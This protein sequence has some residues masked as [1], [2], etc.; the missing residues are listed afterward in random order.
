MLDPALVTTSCAELQAELSSC[1]AECSSLGQQLAAAVAGQAAAQRELGAVASARHE[2]AV[3]R[4]AIQ[5]ELA[6]V[7]TQDC[8]AVDP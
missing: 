4:N 6:Q 8:T 5:R 1:R 3:S 2:E 7:R